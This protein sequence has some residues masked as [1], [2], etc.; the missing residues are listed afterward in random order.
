MNM[1]EWY[2]QGKTEDL[3]ETPTKIA[4]LYTINSTWSSVGLNPGFQGERPATNRLWYHPVI[5]YSRGAQIPA[6]NLPFQLNFVRW[7]LIFF[8]TPL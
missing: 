7:R 1:V 3:G 2:W 8:G 6:V 4:T 5:T